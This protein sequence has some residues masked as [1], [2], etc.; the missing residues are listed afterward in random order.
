MHIH[1]YMYV[2]IHVVIHGM[3]YLWEVH[4]VYHGMVHHTI[5][6]HMYA[7]TYLLYRVCIGNASIHPY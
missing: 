7:S 2:C 6:I 4:A 5:G 3:Y 1:V